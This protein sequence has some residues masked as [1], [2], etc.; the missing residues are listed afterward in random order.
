MTALAVATKHADRL[1][2]L[3]PRA[4]TV[5]G[6]VGDLA[7]RVE[8]IVAGRPRVETP[9]EVTERIEA[10]RDEAVHKILEHTN[11]ARVKL[12]ADRKALA[13]WA[14]MEMAP[15]VAEELARRVDDMLGGAP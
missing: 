6:K 10:R 8:K 7:A 5:L 2:P 15:R 13:A 12:A 1:P 3:H 14:A 11:E 4:A 9:D